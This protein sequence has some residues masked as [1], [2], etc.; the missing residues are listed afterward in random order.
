LLLALAKR[1]TESG[2][3]E[4]ELDGSVEESKTDFL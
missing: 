2:K 1:N 3:M 4:R